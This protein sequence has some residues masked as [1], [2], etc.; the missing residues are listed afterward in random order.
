[1]CNINNFNHCILIFVCL[2]GFIGLTKWTVSLLLSDK[3]V[4]PDSQQY[5]LSPSPLEPDPIRV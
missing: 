1:M 3:D 2:R 5:P 4:I